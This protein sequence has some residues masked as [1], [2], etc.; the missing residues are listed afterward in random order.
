MISAG[1]GI[2]ESLAGTLLRVLVGLV[3]GLA[4]AVPAALLTEAG[5]VR[6]FGL[7]CVAIGLIC[8]LMTFGGSSPTRRMGLQDAYVASFFPRLAGTMGQQYS[9]TTLSDS[10]VFA[11]TGVCLLAIGIVLIE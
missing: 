7:A 8:V 1:M 9:R 6:S 5:F 10:A 3:L 4:I 2:V 11:L